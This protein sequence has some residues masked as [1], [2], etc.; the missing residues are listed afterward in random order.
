[1]RSAA[2]LAITGVAVVGSP[3]IAS[4]DVPIAIALSCAVGQWP[5]WDL[6]LGSDF[7]GVFT[8]SMAEHDRIWPEVQSV[9]V[10]ESGGAF[11]FSATIQF[12]GGGDVT[13]TFRWTL[14]P[15]GD[16][17]GLWHLTATGQYTSNSWQCKPKGAV[18][19]F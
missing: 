7:N 14:I 2:I 19:I 9:P 6:T 5:A 16:G 4:A 1:M 11:T 15:N 3:R 13:D 18:P 17:P 10:Q 8:A 12:L